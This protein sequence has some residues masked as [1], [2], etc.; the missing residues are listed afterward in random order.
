M[1]F[2]PGELENFGVK[3]PVYIA[4]FILALL[5]PLLLSIPAA[6]N[7]ADF[8]DKSKDGK[9]SGKSNETNMKGFFLSEGRSMSHY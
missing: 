7:A 1:P 3:R 5:I 4:C 2:P 8:V 6:H 9:K